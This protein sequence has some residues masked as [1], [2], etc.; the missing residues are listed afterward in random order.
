MKAHSASEAANKKIRSDFAFTFVESVVALTIVAIMLTSLYGGFASGFAT[1][2]V[3]RE[4]LRATQIMVSKLENI[5]LCGF[6]QITNPAYNP[7]TFTE[8]FAP[9]GDATYSGGVVYSG[10]FAPVTPAPGTLPDAYRTNM[11]A[12]TVQL[13]WTSG[14]VVHVRAMQTYA[15]RDGIANYVSGGR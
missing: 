6:D 10:T 12:V 1:V 4:N 9:S 14:N 8:S 11:L 2:R 7:R 15:A 5:R 3:S 13:S